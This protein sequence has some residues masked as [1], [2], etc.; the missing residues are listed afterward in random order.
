M[1]CELYRPTSTASDP[2]PPRA[3]ST[4]CPPCTP[5]LVC[6][7]ELKAQAADLKPEFIRCDN[8]TGAFHYAEKKGYSGVGVYTR[9]APQ[10]IVEG[11]GVP[12]FD[13]EGRYI[14]ADYGRACRHFALPALR[15]EFRGTPAGQVP[16]SRCLLPAPRSADQIRR[17]IVIC[18]DWNIAHREIDLKNWKSNQKNSGFL[19]E[20]RAWMSRLFDELGW[21]DV[22]R[23][24]YP[25]HTRGLYLV[26][27]PRPGL[28]EER[29]LAHRLPDR[30]P[31][32]CRQGQVRQRLQGPAVFRPCAA[33]R[34]LRLRSITVTQKQSNGEKGE[35]RN[36]AK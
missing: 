9:Q 14:E 6:V 25:G 28:G 15:V 26:E 8:L 17:E 32:H 34:R 27:Q 19:P 31:R 13:A 7:Q 1:Q 11:L 10:R 29:R 21:V 24:L 4:G 16:L 3:S 35:E 33:D 30:H 36:G 12:E 5:T 18:G 22:Y 20:E 23:S 2:P